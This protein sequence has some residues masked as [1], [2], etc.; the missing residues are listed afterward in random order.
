MPDNI[1]NHSAVLRI[2]DIQRLISLSRSAIYSRLSDL[3]FPRPIKLGPRAIG[4]LKSDIEAW[5]AGRPRSADS[6][7]AK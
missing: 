3:D 1:S 6:R 4:W 7:R 5:L 2:K